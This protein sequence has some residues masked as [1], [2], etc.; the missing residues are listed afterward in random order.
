MYLE[1]ST[2]LAILK[3]FAEIL[4]HEE[5]IDALARPFAHYVQNQP[6]DAKKHFWGL[7]YAK[8]DLVGIAIFDRLDRSL[9]DDMGIECLDWKKKELENYLCMEEV[10]LAYAKHDLPDD[11][12][13]NAE[14]VNRVNA[15]KE[16]IAEVGSALKTLKKL[17]LWS[18]DVKA[19]DEFLDPLFDKYFEKLGLP[20]LIK[21]SDY[22][23]LAHLVPKDKIN[24]EIAEKLAAIVEI[25]KKAKPRRD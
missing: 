25:A 21:K 20:N 2:D 24:S 19:T 17:D 18:P 22:H 16:S 7:K 10:L 9:P 5:A 13:G 4:E 6:N 8:H 1:G 3:A 23:I 14:A 15:M 11:L 12:F